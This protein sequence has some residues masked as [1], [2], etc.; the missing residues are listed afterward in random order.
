LR[1]RLR[2][3]PLKLPRTHA[4][5]Q[6][7]ETVGRKAKLIRRDHQLNLSLTKDEYVAAYWAAHGAGM[8]L[9]DYGRWRLLLGSDQPLR[10]ERSAASANPLLLA[11][12][13]RLGNN[14]NQLARFCHSTGHA[15][16][17]HLD[18]L[19]LRLREIINQGV[20]E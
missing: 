1:G 20:A 2:L 4:L 8:R 10:P 13:K 7:I 12:M 18:P 5:C 16:P 14:L 3:C 6:E 15:P 17:E 19:L 11:E 9:V